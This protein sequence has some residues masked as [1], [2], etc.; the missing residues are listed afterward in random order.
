MS[1]FLEVQDQSRFG[2]WWKWWTCKESCIFYL[3]SN[4]SLR[5]IN[6]AI[7]YTTICGHSGQYSSKKMINPSLQV[8]ISWPL[9]YWYK[10]MNAYEPVYLDMRH[11]LIISGGHLSPAVISYLSRVLFILVTM[12]IDME[13]HIIFET[14]RIY[15]EGHNYC[16]FYS[17]N[18]KRIQ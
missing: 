10:E 3:P 13:H 16:C 4:F 17:S 6:S 8:C 18:D 11:I 7:H 15:F 12:I 5:N 9:N 2:S 14:I 1:K